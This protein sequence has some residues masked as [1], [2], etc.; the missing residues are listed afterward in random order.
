MRTGSSFN[1][2]PNRVGHGV[3][4]VARLDTLKQAAHSKKRTNLWLRH[5]LVRK[6]A[7]SQWAR[8]L[9]RV[10]ARVVGSHC[11]HTRV[12]LSPSAPAAAPLFLRQRCVHPMHSR[13]PIVTPG[14]EERRRSER[15]SQRRRVVPFGRQLRPGRRT[16][17]PTSSLRAFCLAAQRNY[18][19]SCLNKH[20]RAPAAPASYL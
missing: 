18:V 2:K 11:T 4:C 10:L 8:S 15:V 3:R 14:A 16:K 12:F 19:C 13:A 1:N 7:L 20:G 5:C 9:V 17:P 6:N